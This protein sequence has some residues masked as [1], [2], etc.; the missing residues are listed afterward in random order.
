VTPIVLLFSLAFPGVGGYPDPGAGPAL[1]LSLSLGSP[2][3][4]VGLAMTS[5]AFAYGA[6]QLVYGPLSD[7]RSR[8]AVVRVAGLGSAFCTAASALAV[9]TRQFISI[10]FLA[11]ACAAR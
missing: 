11:G 3:G 1:H 7:R 2:A 9:T 8:I 10:R 5:Y 4:T 6:G